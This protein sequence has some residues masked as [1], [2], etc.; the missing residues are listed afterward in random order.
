MYSQVEGHSVRNENMSSQQ[1]RR[2]R[3]AMSTSSNCTRENRE[4]QEVQW[5]AQN[6]HCSFNVTL[7][8]HRFRQATAQNGEHENPGSGPVSNRFQNG[9]LSPTL[10]PLAPGPRQTAAS[11]NAPPDNWTRPG[12]AKRRRR[13]SS[14]RSGALA[15]A[16]GRGSGF[17][18]RRADRTPVWRVLERPSVWRL[19]V[20]RLQ[21]DRSRRARSALR[22]G[23]GA[24]KSLDRWGRREPSKDRPL[25]LALETYTVRL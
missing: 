2:S 3:R 19:P 7:Q 18:I 16:A 12:R 20:A 6:V 11:R 13:G 25:R 9:L 4:R 8:V 22:G 23:P 10:P 1:I 24:R 14:S 21:S 17:G 5:V 15:L